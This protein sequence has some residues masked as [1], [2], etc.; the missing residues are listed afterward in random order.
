ML[1][2]FYKNTMRKRLLSIF[3]LILL[4]FSNLWN[5]YA[6]N[7]DRSTLIKDLLSSKK[8]LSKTTKWKKQISSINKSIKKLNQSKLENLYNKLEKINT[9]NSKYAK[10]KHLLAYIEAKAGLELLTHM[11]VNDEN[12][13]E[14][15]DQTSSNQK[16]AKNN[17]NTTSIQG[18]NNDTWIIYGKGRYGLWISNI[19][20]TNLNFAET[21]EQKINFSF[22][23]DESV[24]S[25]PWTYWLI[26]VHDRFDFR[27]RNKTSWQIVDISMGATAY[28][29]TTLW[30]WLTPAFF[31]DKNWTHEIIIQ[32]ISNNLHIYESH[33]MLPKATQVFVNVSWIWSWASIQV[34]V[35]ETDN[36]CEATFEW[37]NYRLEP[38]GWIDE[39][40]TKWDWDKNFKYRIYHSEKPSKLIHFEVY[41]SKRLWYHETDWFPTGSIHKKQWLPLVTD[42]Y[43]EY[44]FIFDESKIAEWYY[45]WKFSIWIKNIRWSSQIRNRLNLP[46]NLKVKESAWPVNKCKT[47]NNWVTIYVT[48]CELTVTHFEWFWNTEF[49]Y[50]VITSDWKEYIYNVD[51]APDRS[52]WQRYEWVPAFA[53][54]NNRW[55]KTNRESSFN[56]EIY[57]GYLEK[58]TYKTTMYIIVRFD[59]WQESRALEIPLTIKVK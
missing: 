41:W 22:S 1:L 15:S 40:L 26:S 47:T 10:H 31:W 13:L 8:E 36:D 16:R 58:W 23:F 11:K 6:A 57:D 37:I 2:I 54:N 12:I 55:W 27:I 7:L 4:L 21:I 45:S 28:P 30:L 33:Y 39:E 24:Y 29:W 53:I 50:D 18:A 56:P 59:S 32:P 52:K 19:T 3:A 51:W 35:W 20:T 14:Y 9:N 34:A 49:K 48:P 46:I 42:K 17:P 44:E 5:I 25:T 38:C 43:T